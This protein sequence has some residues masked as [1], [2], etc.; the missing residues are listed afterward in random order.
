LIL[1]QILRPV[2]LDICIAAVF[3]R[4][5]YREAPPQKFALAFSTADVV[6]LGWR[7]ETLAKQLC[8]NELV[9]VRVLPKRYADVD[10]FKT[11]VTSIRITLIEKK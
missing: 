6:I 10:R 11:F 3:Q 8:E 1:C 4:W 2:G 9:M 5:T 7:L